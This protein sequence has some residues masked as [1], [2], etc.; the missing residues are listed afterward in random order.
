MKRV[1]YSPKM[2]ITKRAM[3]RIK[4]LDKKNKYTISSI[5][6][7]KAKQL[8]TGNYAFLRK[9]KYI[10]FL[11]GKRVFVN[12]NA[13]LRIY[14]QLGHKLLGMFWVVPGFITGGI[15]RLCGLFVWRSS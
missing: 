4:N 7:K 15:Y 11:D 1:F 12:A 9:R 8:F 6:G 3:N 13:L 2:A 10:V 5:D 14:W